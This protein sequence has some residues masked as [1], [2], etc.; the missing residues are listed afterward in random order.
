MKTNLSFYSRRSD[1]HRHPKFK[2][3]RQLYGGGDLGW[4]MDAKFWALNDLISEAEYCELDL[5]INRNKADVC[6][7]I[8]LTLSELDSFLKVLISEDV[9]LLE[10]ISPNIFTTK[11]VKE[12]LSSVLV[13]RE[14]ARKRKSSVGKDK[15]SPELFES[16]PE[17]NK[18]GKESKGEEIKGKESKVNTDHFFYQKALNLFKSKTKIQN[19]S[20]EFHL[21]PI[22]SLF[23]AIPEHLTAT[24]IEN[25]INEA[26]QP[27]NEVKSIRMDFLIN[28]IQN[29]ITAKREKKSGKV[30]NEVDKTEV[31]TNDYV[32]QQ[33]ANAREMFTK[34]EQLFSE[35]EK[36]EVNKYLGRN[37]WVMAS[38]LISGKIEEIPSL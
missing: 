14:N 17:P 37:D 30:K 15:S 7:I 4:A 20:F 21:E 5:S 8:G 36:D 34:N 13:E 2:M 12:R 38:S 35:D 27:L 24:D 1:S 19:P 33:L 9:Q 26:F 23:E 16:S 29:K 11:K 28:N 32:A 6:E 31:E 3:L 18:K 25:C 22:C 10:E